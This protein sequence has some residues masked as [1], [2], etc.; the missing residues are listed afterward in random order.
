MSETFYID[1]LANVGTEVQVAGKS[2]K[3]Q[4]I[5]FRNQGELQSVIRK[6]QPRPLDTYKQLK[7]SLDPRYA[8]E[9]VLGL[10]K[11][12]AFWPAPVASPEGIQILLGSETGQ[13]ALL[14]AALSKANS[15]SDD[16]ISELADSMSLSE[17]Q[18][19]AAIAISGEEPSSSPKV[20][21]ATEE[22]KV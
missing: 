5:T 7:S 22:A 2:L 16:D 13:I 20:Q 18:T 14:K 19:I 1:K 10:V 12:E 21:T 8:A 17:F 15:L 9:I 4:Q 3:V 6:I 11:Q